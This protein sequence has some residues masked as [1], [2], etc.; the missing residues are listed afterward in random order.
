M[1]AMGERE[2]VRARSIGEPINMGDHLI[3][4]VGVELQVTLRV[5]PRSYELG[6]ISEAPALGRMLR[7]VADEFEKSMRDA[8]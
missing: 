2:G 3:L 7:E 5:G 8:Q 4:P 6:W 1:P